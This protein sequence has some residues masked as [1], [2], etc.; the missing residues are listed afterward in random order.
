M[1]VYGYITCSSLSKATCKEQD[2]APFLFD[3]ALFELLEVKSAYLG[4]PHPLFSSRHLASYLLL[5]VECEAASKPVANLTTG[6]E[7][8]KSHFLAVKT[9]LQDSLRVA[10]AAFSFRVL[11]VTAKDSA[12]STEC[13]M[14]ELWSV[15]FL[16]PPEASC[17]Y[18]E[19]GLSKK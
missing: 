13:H 19:R 5:K 14:N 18:E 7:P 4:C 11:A 9:Y 17:P 8:H 10:Q 15:G 12:I 6:L 16:L 1:L 3:A 2:I